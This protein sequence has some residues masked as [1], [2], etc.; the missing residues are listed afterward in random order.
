MERA[1]KTI[2]YKYESMKRAGQLLNKLVVSGT[3]N[4]RILAELSYILDS[5]KLGEIFEKEE[6]PNGDSNL[7]QQEVQSNKLEKPSCNVNSVGGDESK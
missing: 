1:M 3:S 4:F 2:T 6:K 7:G 5:G